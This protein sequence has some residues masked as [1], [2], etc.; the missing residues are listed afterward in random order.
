MKRKDAVLF[1]LDYID[2]YFEEFFKEDEN[3]FLPIDWS[4]YSFD[5]VPFQLKGQILNLHVEDLAD[6]I[7]SGEDPELVMKE[8]NPPR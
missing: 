5:E 4:E 6:R 7:L 8:V 1:L 2:C 3:V